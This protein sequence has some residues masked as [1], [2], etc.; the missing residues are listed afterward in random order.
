[1]RPP[2]PRAEDLQWPPFKPAFVE[3]DVYV[4]PEGD[5]WVR[6]SQ[7]AGARPIVF[8]VFDGTGARRMQV[9]VPEGRRVVGFGAGSL[10]AVAR[11]ADDLEW[12]ERYAR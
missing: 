2:A 11:D 1:M 3:Q 10:Y 8:D 6:V 12:L 4:T 9:E 5:L 7:P